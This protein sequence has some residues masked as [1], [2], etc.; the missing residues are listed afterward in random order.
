MILA[1]SILCSFCTGISCSFRVSIQ[2]V[3]GPPVGRD[4]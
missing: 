1:A 3:A 2:S 4:R